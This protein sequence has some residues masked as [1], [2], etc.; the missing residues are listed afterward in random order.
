MG[1]SLIFSD[2]ARIEWHLK[3]ISD[4]KGLGLSLEF[5]DVIRFMPVLQV[6]FFFLQLDVGFIPG[7]GPGS[8]MAIHLSIIMWALPHKIWCPQDRACF[9]LLCK[10]ILNTSSGQFTYQF[11]KCF[12]PKLHGEVGEG[13]SPHQAHFWH[14]EI[15]VLVWYI[16]EDIL[17]DKIGVKSIEFWKCHNFA[18]D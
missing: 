1:V 8:D 2:E 5:W 6:T 11:H 4:W 13:I 10:I 9:Q 12:F 3:E 16:S 7:R 15:S 14:I 18:A 17:H